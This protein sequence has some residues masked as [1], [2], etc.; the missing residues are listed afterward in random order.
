MAYNRFGTVIHDAI[1]KKLHK[2]L[3]NYDWNSHS[4]IRDKISI[5]ECIY[6][7]NTEKKLTNDHY[8]TSIKN[9]GPSQLSNW[10][11][12]IV[13]ACQSCNSK[14]KQ[15]AKNNSENSAFFIELDSLITDTIEYQYIDMDEYNERLEWLDFALTE[16][17]EFLEITSLLSENPKSECKK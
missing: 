17:D 4:F 5:K 10:S 3:D 13:L 6:C 11:N 16:L 2:R 7:K 1:Q 12:F 14:N 9:K 15:V 8:L